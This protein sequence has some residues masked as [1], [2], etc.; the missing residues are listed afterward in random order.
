MSDTLFDMA[1]YKSEAT[2]S[3]RPDCRDTTGTDPAWDEPDFGANDKK[4]N[5]DAHTL[6][7]SASEFSL[8]LPSGQ[9]INVKFIPGLVGERRMHQFDFTGSVSST[10]FKAHF[11]LAVEAEKFPHPRDYAQD[12]AAEL[13]AQMK[14]KQRQSKGTSRTL[15]VKEVEV[16]Q[17]QTVDNDNSTFEPAMAENKTTDLSHVPVEVV[18]ELS[19]EEEADRQRLELEVERAFHKAGLALQ[20]LRSRRLYRDR[21]KTWEQ[22]CQDRF[23]Y[24]YR[25]A[26]LKISAA[27]VFDNLLSNYSQ[28]KMGSNCS[29]ILPT[30]ESQCREL[31][32]L[33]SEQQPSAWLEAI[34]RT[35][36]K[37]VP[38][39][40]TIK[41]VVL[42]RKGIVERLKQKHP[43]PP[44]FGLGDVV[45]IKAVK[46]S[47]LRP[48]NEMCG[49]IERVVRFVRSKWVEILRDDRH[50]WG[51]PFWME[52]ALLIPCK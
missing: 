42:E 9:L 17:G 7:R 33:D 4:P 41:A 45:E 50:L 38:S 28:A 19:P 22:Y 20:E 35:P 13:V 1:P 48:F 36:G 30:K 51:N 14:G 25:F 5:G 32:K 11:V 52:F 44:E 47:P 34:Q 43:P 39:A 29:Q 37:K 18:E 23:G 21:H 49:I 2:Q 12:Y 46:G 16:P 10:G 27:E 15:K 3:Y 24:T 26:N 8:T 31:A 40:S 6:W